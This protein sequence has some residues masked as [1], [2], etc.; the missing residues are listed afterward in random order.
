MIMKKKTSSSRRSWDGVQGWD[1]GLARW[2]GLGW[3]GVQGW[4][5]GLGRCA[6]LGWL[7]GLGRCAGLG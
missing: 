7:A 4:D 6:G 3:D 5:Y 2:A 1:D